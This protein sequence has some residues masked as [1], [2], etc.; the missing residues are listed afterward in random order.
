M[1]LFE[2]FSGVSLLKFARQPVKCIAFVGLQDLVEFLGLDM[3]PDS[4]ECLYRS[5]IDKKLSSF[6]CVNVL[7]FCNYDLNIY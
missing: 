1:Y 6:Y 3:L 5:V 2:L 4:D 7:L